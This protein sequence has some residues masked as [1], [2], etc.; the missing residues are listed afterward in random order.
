MKKN[1]YVDWVLDSGR[2]PQWLLTEYRYKIRRV[3]QIRRIL[4]NP[5]RINKPS[6][7]AHSPLEI[8]T[9]KRSLPIR[10]KDAE[11]CRQA[12]HWLARRGLMGD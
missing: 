11:E 7:R 12:I 2:N 4:N 5:R 9:Y 8:R 1:F 3:T 6:G 10:E